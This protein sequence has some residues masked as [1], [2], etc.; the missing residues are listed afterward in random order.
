MKICK[1]NPI[2]GA[3]VIGVDLSQSISDSDF[4]NIHEAFVTHSVLI[5]RDQDLSPQNMVDFSRRFGPLMI[6][7]LKES[8]LEGYPE[9]YKLS[10]RFKN[11][12]QDGRAYAGQYWHSDLTYEPQPSLGSLLYGIE[13]PD[14][15]GDTLFASTSHAYE[16]LSPAMQKMLDGLT[17]EHLFAHAFRASIN[18]R[19]RNGDPLHERPAVHHP[20]VRPHKVTGKKCLFINEGFTVK[21]NELRSEENNAMLRFLFDHMTSP[22]VVLRHHW[23]VGDAVL[24]DNRS[25]IHRGVDDYGDNKIRHMHRTTIREANNY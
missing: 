14:Y 24:W 22:E 21:I 13:V 19:R 20:V 25:L 12:T 9:I 17:A 18:R 3:E 1:L 11:G 16:T 4:T 10:N 6:H 7:V 5:F 2:L 15:G 23:R 8:L